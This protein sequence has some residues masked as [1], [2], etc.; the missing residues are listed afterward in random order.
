MKESTAY[1]YGTP[2]AN[3][4]KPA[5]PTRDGG[6]QYTYTFAGWSPTI[7]TV[8]EDATYT[9]TYTETVNQYNIT[10]VDWD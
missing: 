3:I 1:D 4:V 5:D 6:A 7:V 9:A 2:A 10:F 8:T